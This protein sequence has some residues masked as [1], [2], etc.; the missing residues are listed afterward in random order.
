MF[1]LGTAIECLLTLSN[2]LTDRSTVLEF[3]LVLALPLFPR[4]FFFPKPLGGHAG[5]DRFQPWMGLRVAEKEANPRYGTIYN[6]ELGGEQE[7]TE[8]DYYTPASPINKESR[9]AQTSKPRAKVVG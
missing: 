2:Q 6:M 5:S 9:G 1:F 8:K 3:K 7:W 4:F